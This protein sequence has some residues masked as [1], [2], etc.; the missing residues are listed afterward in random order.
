MQGKGHFPEIFPEWMYFRLK[1]DTIRSRYQKSAGSEGELM[2]AKEKENRVADQER[3]LFCRKTAAECACDP[4]E[5]RR[6][7]RMMRQLQQFLHHM[8]EDEREALH[9]RM[10]ERK[11]QKDKRIEI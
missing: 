8:D 1:C 6:K 10:E 3:C 5:K 4:W 11:K 2:A 7:E 9:K